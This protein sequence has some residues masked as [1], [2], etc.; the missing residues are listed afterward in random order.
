MTIHT[1]RNAQ[2]ARMER[3]A[4]RL[5]EADYA[6]LNVFLS[7]N[8]EERAARWRML[9]HGSKFRL[10]A[11]QITALGY[12]WMPSDVETQIAK[13]DAKW[14]NGQRESDLQIPPAAAMLARA[15]EDHHQAQLHG[16]AAGAAQ[17]NRLRTNI[18][19]GARLM[20]VLGDLLIQSVNNP[21]SVYSV[22]RAG[23]TCPN[24][25]AGKAA[26]WHVALFDLLLAML[27]TAA[28]TADMEA[29]PGPPDIPEEPSPP[30]EDGPEPPEWHAPIGQRLAA[31]RRVCMGV[32]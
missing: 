8:G 13:Y 21:G 24:G 23:C 3:D 18:T 26:C 9:D 7:L 17:L 15:T 11:R 30:T 12:D 32:T 10:V 22:N 6:F 2:D 20:W 14:E 1:D 28:E 5:A 4:L 31:A 19:R 27:D 25:A 29:E 16:D